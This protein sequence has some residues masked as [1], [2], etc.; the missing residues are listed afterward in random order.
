MDFELKSAGRNFVC[1]L[2]VDLPLF[3]GTKAQTVAAGVLRQDDSKVAP[4][5]LHVSL[6]FLPADLD[7]CTST[8][9]K[10]LPQTLVMDCWRCTSAIC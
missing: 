9:V 2:G 4:E 3:A 6:S 1:A 5:R 8:N 7:P 10:T